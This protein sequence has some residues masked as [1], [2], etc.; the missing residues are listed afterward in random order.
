MDEIVK[1][2]VC[3]TFMPLFYN[4]IYIFLPTID[5]FL[6]TFLVQKLN[7]YRERVSLLYGLQHFRNSSIYG[8]GGPVVS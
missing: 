1:N 8:L 5:F 2:T 6:L 7:E 3:G 4:Q